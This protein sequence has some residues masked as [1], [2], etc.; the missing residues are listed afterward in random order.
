MKAFRIGRK[1]PGIW[2]N[3]TPPIRGG[4]Y[5]KQATPTPPS[6]T[7]AAPADTTKLPS[8][9]LEP[10][11]LWEPSATGKIFAGDAAAYTNWAEQQEIGRDNSD[12]PSLDPQVQQDIARKYSA[13]HQ[14]I[15][16]EGYYNCPYLEY[17]KEMAR[18]TTLFAASM[19]A[20]WHE[21]YMTS[22]FFL[23]LFWHQIMFTAHDAAHGAITGNFEVDSLIAMFI[24]DFCCGLSIGWWKSSHNVHH[25]ITNHP[26][27]FP[28]SLVLCWGRGSL[29]L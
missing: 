25:L 3:K 5:Q 24:G 8:S 1:P 2:T 29:M 14:R 27:G 22:A 12:Y 7:A 16:D 17:G 11:S 9:A 21:W 18:Y 26:V 15:H 19:V 23:G 28:T 13:L 6:T 20:L 4:I 10:Q